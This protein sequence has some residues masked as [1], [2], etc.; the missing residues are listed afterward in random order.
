MKKFL[1]LVLQ[2]NPR[3]AVNLLMAADRIQ[4]IPSVRE[5]NV[6]FQSSNFRELQK[7]CYCISYYTCDETHSAVNPLN[8]LIPV[9]Q[10]KYIDSS[11]PGNQTFPYKILDTTESWIAQSNDSLTFNEE[12]VQQISE[13][14]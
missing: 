9:L 8:I 11:K 13:G 12:T 10:K 2:E 6:T 7:N 4:H 3:R 1:Y 5:S 14:K